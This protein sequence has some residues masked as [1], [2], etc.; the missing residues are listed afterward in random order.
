MSQGYKAAHVMLTG[1]VN[2]ILLSIIPVSS[3]PGNWGYY[4]LPGTTECIAINVAS[5]DSLTL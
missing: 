5:V 2:T 4:I 3:L 1:C